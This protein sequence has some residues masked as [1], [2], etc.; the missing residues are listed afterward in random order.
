MTD[1]G[2]QTNVAVI[3]CGY[4]G[5]NYVRICHAL[6]AINCVMICDAYQGSLDKMKDQ[7]P[8]IETTTSVD[9]VV[10][11]DDIEACFVVVPATMHYEVGLKVL[12]NNKHLLM[13]K[14]FTLDVSKGEILKQLAAQNG[15][16][17][18]VGH[19]FLYNNRV[20]MIRQL[21]D[22]GRIGSLNTIYA[23]RT[24]LG[25]IRTDTSAVWDLAPHDISIFLYAMSG[26]MPM[27]VSA[28]GQC[29]LPSTKHVDVAFISLFF[30][31][32]IM[33]HIHVSWLDPQK[34]RTVTFVGESGRISFDDTS[35]IEPIRVYMKGFN[36]SEKEGGEREF[37]YRDGDIV[38]P[39]VVDKEPL[40]AQVLD[41]LYSIQEKRQPISSAD[42]GI[43]VSKILNAVDASIKENGKQILLE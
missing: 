16:N 42:L 14:P 7:Y 30:P 24:N 9:E 26:I 21:I 43:K 33:G 10:K 8:G 37:T 4:W 23:Q 11:R 41:F 6:K 20:K 32:N 1:I 39:M 35:G 3:G 28:T 2:K 19:T 34:V 5:K 38:S 12:N 15:L 17:I 29:V 22:G 40:K 36:R 31:G 25:P 18:L 27:A 13:E